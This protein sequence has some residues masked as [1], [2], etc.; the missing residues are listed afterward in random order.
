VTERVWRQLLQD[1]LRN[2]PQ[3]A[4]QNA[5]VRLAL[6]M[7]GADLRA[8]LTAVQRQWIRDRLARV[9]GGTPWPLLTV[10]EKARIRA[11]L[12]AYLERYHPRIAGIVHEQFLDVEGQQG[13]HAS[14]I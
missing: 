8:D 6:C 11:P 2:A 12:L 7:F 1:T 10:R 3:T 5:V 13:E 4:A 14:S 9:P